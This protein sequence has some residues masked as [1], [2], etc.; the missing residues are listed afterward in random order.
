MI[1]VSKFPV[2]RSIFHHL[3]VFRRATTFCYSTSINAGFEI[4]VKGVR[5]EK[6]AMELIKETVQSNPVV[7]FMKGSATRPLCG[8]SSRVTQILLN[9]PLNHPF[10]TVNVLANEDIRSAIKKFSDWP[11]VP[12]LY[13][14]GKFVG[15]CDIAHEM[16]I[17]GS[18]ISLL[19]DNQLCNDEKQG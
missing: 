4:D 11:T 17:N 16:Y 10:A 7:L 2:G 5:D 8:F 9:S 3:S 1:S 13:V 18:F 15:G 6:E 12:Q 14:K 19:K